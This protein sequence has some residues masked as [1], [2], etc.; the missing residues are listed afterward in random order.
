M[1]YKRYEFSL[2]YPKPLAKNELK[3]LITVA[4]SGLFSRYASDYTKK[5]EIDLARYYGKKHAVTCTSG[6]AALHGCLT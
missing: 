6:T 2:Q 3:D 5:L 4:R 1:K